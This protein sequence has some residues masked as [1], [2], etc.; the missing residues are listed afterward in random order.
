MWVEVLAWK[1]G[2][3]TGPL[4]NDPAL[5]THLRAGQIVTV[6]EDRIF[7]YIHRL[8]NGREEGNT[9]GAILDQRSAH[10]RS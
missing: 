1:Q 7:D 4:K 2:K 8:P 10:P 6:G 9:T 5:A 3:I